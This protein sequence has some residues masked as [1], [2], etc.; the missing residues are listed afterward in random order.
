MKVDPINSV[1]AD[2]MQSVNSVTA[3]FEER[4]RA[5]ARGEIDSA[6]VVGMIEDRRV[7]EADLA[8]VRVADEMIGSLLDVVA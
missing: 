5:I 1:F 7:V 2:S 8:T 4:A 6:D 3:R